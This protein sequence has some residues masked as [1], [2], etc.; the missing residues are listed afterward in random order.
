MDLIPETWLNFLQI[1][2]NVSKINDQTSRI[3]HANLAART[4][5][6]HH[7]PISWV[8]MGVFVGTSP[9]LRNM[10]KHTKTRAHVELLNVSN[11]HNPWSQGF[12]HAH[13]QK[14]YLSTQTCC[15]IMTFG[16]QQKKTIRVYTS[17][18]PCTYLRTTLRG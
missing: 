3:R 15:Q 4:Q 7:T 16:A 14:S 2:S 5:E 18:H 12:Q 9:L 10:R 8:R 17:V 13:R 6:W 11:A 1:G